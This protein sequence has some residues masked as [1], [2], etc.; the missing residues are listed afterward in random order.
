[1]DE[2]I[3]NQEKPEKPYHI[4]PLESTMIFSAC[5]LIGAFGIDDFKQIITDENLVELVGEDGSIKRDKLVSIVSIRA[6]LQALPIMFKNLCKCQD[7]L[8]LFLEEASDLTT[9][10]IRHLSPANMFRMI[11]DIVKSPESKDF[12]SVVSELLE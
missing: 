9:D 2:K 1:M 7:E 12:F 11:V 5:N 3:E 8:Y 10:Q 4:K 6:L